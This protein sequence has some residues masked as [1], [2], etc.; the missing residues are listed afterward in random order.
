LIGV[1]LPPIALGLVGKALGMTL[2]AG[3]QPDKI[4]DAVK[5]AQ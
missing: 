4:L 3:V 1:R 2:S 5:L